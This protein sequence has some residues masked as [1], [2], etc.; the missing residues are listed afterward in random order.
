MKQIFLGLMI[1]IVFL[2]AYAQSVPSYDFSTG[3]LYLPQ[4]EVF[5]GTGETIGLFEAYLETI[6]K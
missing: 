3:Q 5:S 2:R 6:H 1:L 4:V